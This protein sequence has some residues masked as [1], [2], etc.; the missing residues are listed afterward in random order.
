MLI[1]CKCSAGWM[2]AGIYVN[3][4][5]FSFEKSILRKL[6]YFLKGLLSAILQRYLSPQ[7]QLGSGSDWFC[8]NPIGDFLWRFSCISGSCCCLQRAILVNST[9]FVD[10]VFRSTSPALFQPVIWTGACLHNG[11]EG[12]AS[13]ASVQ[14]H[15]LPKATSNPAYSYSPCWQ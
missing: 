11:T 10:M 3:S 15:V 1:F 5:H 6:H 13:K 8:I 7:M 4:F 2:I 12:E 14:Y 9:V